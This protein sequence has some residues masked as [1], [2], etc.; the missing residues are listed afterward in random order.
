MCSRALMAQKSRSKDV[1]QARHVATICR[2]MS[3]TYCACGT[4]GLMEYMLARVNRRPFRHRW[5]IRN[6][7]TDHTII[8]GDSLRKQ[9]QVRS[10]EVKGQRWTDI[11]TSIV[12]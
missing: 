12:R 6:Q 10:A 11:L 1:A 3:S 5:N 4:T 2:V 7:V 9:P 8:K